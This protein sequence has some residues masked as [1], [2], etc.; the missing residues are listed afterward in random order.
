[1]FGATSCMMTEVCGG[2]VLREV[3]GGASCTMK[4]F[5]ATEST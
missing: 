4:V 1:M 3:G 5:G 2:T